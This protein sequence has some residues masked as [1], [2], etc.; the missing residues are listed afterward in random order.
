MDIRDLLYFKAIVESKT[1]AEASAKIRISQPGLTY[2]VKRLENELKIE[3]FD[4]VGNVRKLN[5]AGEILYKHA[6]AII[7]EQDMCYGEL[8]DYTNRDRIFRMSACDP[9]PRW[10]F[11]QKF[12]INYPQLELDSHTYTDL[13]YAFRMLRGN[14]Y[15]MLITDTPIKEEGIIC[16]FFA[17]DKI[18]LSVH[19]EDK[20]FAQDKE[21]SLHDPRVKDLVCYHIEGSFSQKLLKIYKEIGEDTNLRLENDLYIFNTILKSRKILTLN[22]RI[23]STYRLDGNNRQLIPVI[24]EGSSIN[25]YI[26]YKKQDKERLK[27]LLETIDECIEEFR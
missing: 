19:P 7:E 24:D 16:K 23:V 17:E 22:T 15:D 5:Q 2:A 4:R 21:I 18:M 8:K 3:L 20:R 9:G 26:V 25:Y 11:A 12:T 14:R 1:L 10:Y 27:Y 6:N 13:D